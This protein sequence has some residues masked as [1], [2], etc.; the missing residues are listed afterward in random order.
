[1][2]DSKPAEK[3]LDWAGNRFLRTKAL[4]RTACPDLTGW[5]KRIF[6]S[7]AALSG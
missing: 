3:R 7:A 5:R 4:M 1:M 6:E 2:A